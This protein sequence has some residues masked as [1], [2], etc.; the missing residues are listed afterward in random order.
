MARVSIEER[1][2][3][4]AKKV[5]RLMGWTKTETIGSLYCL[6]HDSQ[7]LE[8][9]T[10][11]TDDIALW[12]E[13]D[14][15]EIDNLVPALVNAKFI[16]FQDDGTYLICGNEKHIENLR[17]RR[18]AAREGGLRSGE[19]RALKASAKPKNEA[20]ASNKIEANASTETQASDE[21]SSLQF[22]A[23]LCNS[24][25]GEEARA[26]AKAAPPGGILVELWQKNSGDLPK[27]L[28]TQLARTHLEKI[29]ERL[30]E[31]P[32][33]AYWEGIIQKLATTPFFLGKNKRRWKADFL[34]LI[35]PENHVKIAMREY[36]SDEDEASAALDV[37]RW[38]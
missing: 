38:K 14:E 16:E 18:E 33:P 20:L 21:A 32:D 24:K 36:G 25:K 35:E 2:A 30:E 10:C 28:P 19:V 4:A 26:R 12:M 7:E 23:V 11:T 1:A 3:V 31:N 37:S 15:T 9:T 5:A 8:Q 13:V 29:R 6:W 27:I 17:Q 22:S 34:W